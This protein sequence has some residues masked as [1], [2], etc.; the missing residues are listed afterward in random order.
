[1][2][3]VAELSRVE[4]EAAQGG[5]AMDLLSAYYEHYG[6]PHEGP[7]AAAD[8]YVSVVPPSSAAAPEPPAQWATH[9]D[10][11]RR[12]PA[13]S[14]EDYMASLGA[15]G[16]DQTEEDSQLE[17]QVDVQAAPVEPASALVAA[18]P[19]EREREAEAAP[20]QLRDEV[21]VED[22]LLDVRAGYDEHL[23]K[24]RAEQLQRE[25][26]EI[27]DKP[28][29]TDKAKR[30]TRGG[31]PVEERLMSIHAQ[32]Q[33]KRKKVATGERVPDPECTHSPAIN[34]TSRGKVA[35][36]S[37]DRDG[38]HKKS[39]VEHLRNKLREEEERGLQDGP[40]INSKSRRM[41]AHRT[42]GM[43]VEDYLLLNDRMHKKEMYDRHEKRVV[44]TLSDA[45]PRITKQAAALKR[46]GDFGERLY[47]QRIAGNLMGSSA[48][49]QFSVE[50]S[51]RR[52][53]GVLDA[54]GDRGEKEPFTPNINKRSQSRE[55]SEIP[56]EDRLYEKY[57]QAQRDLEARREQYENEQKQSSNT[58]HT[59]KQSQMLFTG[60]VAEEAHERLH[61]QS[62]RMRMP[63]DTPR[64]P[65]KVVTPAAFSG[66]L[67][68][69]NA[70]HAKNRMETEKMRAEQ[71]RREMKECT[72]DPFKSP[73]IRSLRNN[74]TG[75]GY[76]ARLSTSHATEGSM[77][78]RSSTWVKR[79]DQRLNKEQQEKGHK[80][81]QGCTFVP[82]TNRDVPK[83]QALADQNAN[84]ANA[85]GYQEFVNRLKKAR[86][87]KVEESQ[88]QES[89]F[90][91]GEKWDGRPTVPKEFTFGARQGEIKSLGKMEPAF[92]LDDT[93]DDYPYASYDSVGAPR[94]DAA[95]NPGAATG[96]R[97]PHS[98]PPS[99]TAAQQ[100][101]D[102]RGVDDFI[103]SQHASVM[104]MFGN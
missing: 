102:C 62:R 20:G 4:S 35:R 97:R 29:I 28:A 1:M 33:E 66:K 8:G 2:A 17:E 45:R 91:T 42:G 12:P 41:A 98:R 43:N 85:Y 77:A 59:S 64:P 30:L 34:R 67:S 76:R 44:G 92:R 25:M 5:G 95:P 96:V 60:R 72:F 100:A 80:E 56:I 53:K 55:R 36:Y 83:R 90:T 71:Q 103:S 81:M 94:Y 88:R 39:K 3:N 57:K 65:K 19:E 13:P 22:W 58:V 89:A 73:T 87:D 11:C 75:R 9:V 51:T 49:E 16:E 21:R 6:Y 38:N 101:G 104:A 84:A 78:E 68:E 82:Y 7:P 10:P 63:D 18:P 24:L 40:A 61:R 79:R 31:V 23:Q 69:W 54:L 74:S 99:W 26:L 47:S 15:I 37:L 48:L 50:D 70:K 86:D 32:Q 27:R 93:D 46:D 14:V 52:D